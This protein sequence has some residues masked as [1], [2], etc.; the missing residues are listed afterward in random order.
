MEPRDQKQVRQVRTR[1]AI[2]LV[3]VG[4]G[5]PLGT[6]KAEPERLARI[7]RIA[8]KHYGAP[9]L[10]IADQ[11]A[12]YWMGRNNNPYHDEIFNVAEYVGRPGAY[13]L[14]NSFEWS[15]TAAI[16]P[17]IHRTGNRMLRTL[18][19]PMDG[20]G[21]NVIVA[22]VP[23]EEGPY[24]AVTWPGFSGVL[25]A[26]A[27]GR[28]SAAI[29]Q[30]PMRSWTRAYPVDWIVNR[31]QM[32]RN[33]SLPPV[34]LLRQVFDH[35]KNFEEALEVLSS[36]PIAM[37]AFFTLS[38]I[39]PRENALIERTPFEA[40]VQIGPNAITNHWKNM[41]ISSYK[42]GVLS[43]ERLTQMDGLRYDTPNTFGWVTAPILNPTTRL[44][45]I[46]NAAEGHLK[47]LGWEL[48]PGV[49]KFDLPVP[50]TQVYD[51]ELATGNS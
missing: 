19:W 45:V 34:H 37:P 31:V 7:L 18:D 10:S 4:D 6:A 26:M 33:I 8:T 17:D 35:C 44:S 13:L 9:V 24:D 30:P 48:E 28:F 41:T 46:A 2:P 43:P 3:D 1:N 29:N 23:G 20:L 21:A 40:T 16:G 27:P 49:K 42:R 15:C 36:E 25:T 47:V 51:S 50:A 11:L 32:W 12:D 39:G 5:G 38:G 22:R 14:N